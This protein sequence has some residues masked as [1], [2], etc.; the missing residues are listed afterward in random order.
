MADQRLEALARLLVRY[1]V[2]AEPGDRVAIRCFGSQAAALPAQALILREVLRAGAHPFPL[3]LPA[4]TSEFDYLFFSEAQDA[5]LSRPN[6]F[7]ELLARDFECD[8]ILLCETNTRR[9]SNVDTS[10][11]A[12]LAR[13]NT[14]V[15]NLWLRRSGAGQLRWV[16]CGLPT[17]AYAQDAEMSFEEYETFI[18]T[19]TCVDVDDPVTEWLAMGK[20]Q[21]M[22]VDWLAGKRSAQVKGPHIDLAFSVE[23][24]TFENCDGHLNMP[25]GEIFTAPVED[26]VSG[27]LESTYPAIFAGVDV[28]EVS[29]RFKEGVL[30]DAQAKRNQS[31]LTKVLQTDEGA[32]RVG[33]FGIGTNDRI[34]I[35]TKNMLFD[36]KMGGTV[37]VALGAAYP[38]TGGKNESS[39]HWDF[40]CDMK[41][42]G[43]IIIDGVPFYDSGRFLI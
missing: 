6:P 33:E 42:G 13:A 39:V 9:L 10:R 29:L 5:Q 27:W 32:R 34:S 40:L 35:F 17:Q 12:M 20:R 23:G 2:R 37:H 19:T 22:L 38:Q 4:S 41:H 31:H 16:L 15:F 11:Q 24:R 8:I 21:K 3:I 25:D 1:S 18:Y 28:G 36:E 43:Q 14:N 26:T 30:T 7:H